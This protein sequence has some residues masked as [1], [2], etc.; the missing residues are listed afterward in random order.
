MS[1]RLV[2]LIC[3]TIPLCLFAAPATLA[4][5]RRTEPQQTWLWVIDQRT[6]LGIPGAS[7]DIGPG[8]T[9][10]GR[11]QLGHAKWTAHYVTGP[12]GRVL[13]QGLPQDFSCRVTLNG[14][15]LNVV[16]TGREGR[17]WTGP[18]WLHLKHALQATIEMGSDNQEVETADLD[19]WSTTNDPTRFLAYI[20]DLDTGQLIAGVKVAALRS[21][22]TA[23]SDANGLFTLEIPASYRKGKTP[24]TAIETLVFSKPEY[25]RYEYHDL[26]LNPGLIPLVIYLE[27]GAGTVV[28]KNLSRSNGATPNDEFLT[29]QGSSQ[30]A[31]G[32][33]R[34]EIISLYIEPS[35]VE[36]GWIVCKQAGAKAV[37][38]GRNLKSVEIFWYSTGTGIGLMPPAKAGPLR[39]VSA[40]PDG[41]T[42]EIELPDLMAT[43]FWAQGI[44]AHGNVVKSM[45]LGNVGW[46]VER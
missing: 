19:Y 25:C 8:A 12:A 7:V 3:E 40:S 36:G 33:N 6:S 26:V 45:N 24:P 38:K 17:T 30:E 11:A 34:G 18:K 37:V 46:D 43:D 10:L 13:T 31:Q 5:G 42:W 14:R 27:K 28:H 9:C 4:Q 39:K 29:F 23:T 20:Q 2:V 41:D 16:S 15:E 21:G 32:R 35:V 44:D 22:I 1:R